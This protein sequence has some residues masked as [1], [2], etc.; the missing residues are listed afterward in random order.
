MSVVEV[1][2]ETTYTITASSGVSQL[3]A[4]VRIT[5]NSNVCN[6]MDGVPVMYSGQTRTE[7]CDF[8]GNK[9]TECKLNADA[10]TVSLETDDSQ[11]TTFILVFVIVI[12]VVVLI[13][14]IVMLVLIKGLE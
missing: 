11:C 3:S 4:T 2:T 14:V 9:K 13:L 7:K 8:L 5:V 1:T 10:L 6:S 12:V